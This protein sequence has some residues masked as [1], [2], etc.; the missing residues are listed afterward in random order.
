MSKQSKNMSKITLTQELKNRLCKTDLS[1]VLSKKEDRWISGCPELEIYSDGYSVTEAIKNVS[2]S[3]SIFLDEGIKTG[4]L[5]E[6]LLDLGWTVTGSKLEYNS[7]PLQIVELSKNEQILKLDIEDIL[8]VE[9]NEI[10]ETEFLLSN[11]KNRAMFE[12]ALEE[13]NSANTK[14]ITKTIEELENIQNESLVA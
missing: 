9:K 7:T 12:Q 1:I 13:L 2:K 6:W 8:E 3:I 10:D 4:E 5:R 14:M 11:P